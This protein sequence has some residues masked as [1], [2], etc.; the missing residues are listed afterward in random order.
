MGNTRNS[1]AG[2]KLKSFFFVRVLLVNFSLLGAGRAGCAIALFS[3]FSNSF[4]GPTLD[5]IKQTGVV[6]I[7][8]QDSLPFSYKHP[9]GGVPP[10][11]SIEVCQAL[12]EAIKN[13]HKLKSVEVRYVPV[14][15]ASRIPQV[16]EGKVDFVCAGVTNTKPRREQVA[17][18]LPVYFAAAKLLVR[19]GSGIAR[20]DDLDGKT[21]AV[22]KGT[23]GA[24]IAEARRAGRP[25]I[26]LL[27]VE[28]AGDGVKAVETKAAD[29]FIQD[30]IQLHG[31]K[32]QSSER[33]S[34]VGAGLS[35]EPLAIMFGKDDRELGALVDREMGQLYKSGQMRKLYT[36]WFQTTLPLRGYNLNVT[37]NQLTADMFTSP[38]GY[39]ADWAIF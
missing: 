11:Y 25:G 4:A 26:K 21:L 32:A 24:Q 7:G 17:F 5:R 14:T 36:K 34:V 16:L 13:E 30:D 19:E 37:P 10:G 12:V 29:A 33:L 6:N 9:D 31:L 27:V 38:S 23:T 35:I 3:V 15:G 18:S 2:I 8:Y 22:Q 1:S 28:T 39:T 20:I